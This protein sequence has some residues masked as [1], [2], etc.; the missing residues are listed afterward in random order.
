MMNT[1]ELYGRFGNVLW[2]IGAAIRFFGG[3]ENFVAVL[4]RSFKKKESA[5]FQGIQF[6]EQAQIDKN[7][8]FFFNSPQFSPIPPGTKH[9]RGWFQH[10]KFIEGVD[11]KRYLKISP[12]ENEHTLIHIR[13]TDYF[14][15]ETNRK[16]FP[17]HN[18]EYYDRGMEE[19]GVKPGECRIVTDDRKYARSLLP[20]IQFLNNGKQG[21]AVDFAMM[22]GAQHVICSTSTFSW[23]AGYLGKAERVIIPSRWHH[24]IVP[25]EYDGVLFD[26]VTVIGE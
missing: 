23:W 26:R 14:M 6:V 7:R 22:M 16:R 20:E 18:R 19:L 4:G 13:G 25:Q 12:Q 11:M 17:V 15:N 21:M 8:K 5:L 9:L 2:E 3:P 1:I 24:G 10:I